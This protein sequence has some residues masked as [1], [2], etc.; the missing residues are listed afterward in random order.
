MKKIMVVLMLFVCFTASA[1]WLSVDMAFQ[2]NIY[3]YQPTMIEL[4]EPFDA[5]FKI[6]AKLFNFIKI[7]GSWTTL[8]SYCNGSDI[9]NFFPTGMTYFIYG[10]IEPIKGISIIYEHSC[11]HPV[12]AYFPYGTFTLDSSYSRLYIEIKGTFDF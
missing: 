7:G 2:G 12:A 1:D 10:G 11:S 6:D 5:V 3:F 9:I 8:F 4:M